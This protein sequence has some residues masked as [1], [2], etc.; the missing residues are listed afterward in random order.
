MSV[1]ARFAWPCLLAFVV[2]VPGGCDRGAA[3]PRAAPPPP[4]IEVLVGHGGAWQAEPVRRI[5]GNI[6]GIQLAKGRLVDP[7][8]KELETG[9]PLPRGELRRVAEVALRS[10]TEALDPGLEGELQRTVEERTRARLVGS[11]YRREFVVLEVKAGGSRV[12]VVW[13]PLAAGAARLPIPMMEPWERLE[14]AADAP[15]EDIVR[16]AVDLLAARAAVAAEK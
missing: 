13:S 7:D 9:D 1:S 4:P 2:L 16:A 15:D 5:E 6:A 14:V 10:R 8:G 11:E 12:V 3:A